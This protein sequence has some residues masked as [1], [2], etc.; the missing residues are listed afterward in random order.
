M[1]NR[2]WV[3]LFLLAAVTAG[4]TSAAEDPPS[5]SS[6]PSQSDI[7][8]CVENAAEDFTAVYGPPT[9]AE[10]ADMRVVCSASDEELVDAINGS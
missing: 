6:G 10:R 3:P 4:C 1:K 8:E 7:E 5:G 9:A 2:W